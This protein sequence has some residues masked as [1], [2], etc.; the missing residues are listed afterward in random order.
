[1]TRRHRQAHAGCRVDSR[2]QKALPLY[3][4]GPALS[5]TKPQYVGDFLSQDY[6][7]LWKTCG[8]RSEPE[9]RCSLYG[10]FTRSE[11]RA[12]IRCRY[13]TAVGESVFDS[14]GFPP[15]VLFGFPPPAPGLSA[16]AAPSLPAWRVGG[17]WGLSKRA[18]I[19]HKGATRTGAN[20]QP[21]RKAGRELP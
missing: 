3:V 4:S 15:L 7:R 13:P 8:R 12:K 1:M 18:P 14:S 9:A 20:L 11:S 5:T 10:V 2:C 17:G 21:V 19:G 6:H 16:L